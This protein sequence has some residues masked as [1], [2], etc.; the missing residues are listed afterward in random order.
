MCT[1]N[2][3]CCVVVLLKCGWLPRSLK[4]LFIGRNGMARIDHNS[5]MS[6]HFKRSHRNLDWQE[7]MQLAVLA[8]K[9][10][11]FLLF[12]SHDNKSALNALFWCW[13]NV[14]PWII[15]IVS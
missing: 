14:S 13:Y 4:S 1:P 11:E 15:S 6:A 5:I 12:T 3:L 7:K 8:T 10:S 2:V 9:V